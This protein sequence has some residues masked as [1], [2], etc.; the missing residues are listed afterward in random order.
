MLTIYYY[1]ANSVK[2]LLNENPPHYIFLSNSLT[3]RPREMLLN[4]SSSQCGTLL[5]PFIECVNKHNFSLP[6]SRILQATAGAFGKL[7]NLK[8][9]Y[10]CK[11]R[12]IF[13]EHFYLNRLIF[14]DLWKIYDSPKVSKNALST[15]DKINMS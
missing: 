2:L 3:S 6:C 13:T 4:H 12:H 8:Q 15:L 14:C 1:Q 7:E 10:L 5:V 11:H 9:R